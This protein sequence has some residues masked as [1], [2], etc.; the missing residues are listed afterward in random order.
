MSK[1]RKADFLSTICEQRFN[2]EKIAQMTVLSTK[3]Q[4]FQLFVSP[5]YEY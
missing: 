2:K 5:Y 4:Q 3:E 1:K